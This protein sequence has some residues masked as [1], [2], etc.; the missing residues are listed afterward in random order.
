MLVRYFSNNL[1]NKVFEGGNPGGA[2]VF[3][4]YHRKLQ[5]AFSQLRQ[6][7]IHMQ[8]LRH[9][10]HVFSEGSGFK[11]FSH[12]SGHTHSFFDMYHAHNIVPVFPIQRKAGMPGGTCQL[13]NLS[14]GGGIF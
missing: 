4:E 14:H 10:K 7:G 5:G 12:L 3:V 9:L 2:P 11:G 6:E 1:F 13:N 8:G